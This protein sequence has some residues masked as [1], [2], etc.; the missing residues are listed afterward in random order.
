V[1]ATI[2]AIVVVAFAILGAGAYYF[3]QQNALVEPTSS[4]EMRGTIPAETA[5]Q[6]TTS[7][8]ASSTSPQGSQTVS[9]DFKYNGNRTLPGRFYVSDEQNPPENKEPFIV[10][11][12]VNETS[13]MFGIDT[14]APIGDGCSWVVRAT[15]EISGRRSA[16]VD[17]IATDV[18]NLV[19]I[20]RKTAPEMVC[21]NN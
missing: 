1:S 21:L 2:L 14:A 5:D 13:K 10:F 19:S 17:D 8:H 4:E 6:Q 9:G 7:T 18:A 3:M 11:P 16:T 15:I 12:N 20:T